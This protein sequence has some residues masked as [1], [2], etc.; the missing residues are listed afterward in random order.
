MQ[1]TLPILHSS[2]PT[3]SPLGSKWSDEDWNNNRHKK[4]EERKKE[5]Q[6]KEEAKKKNKE[7]SSQKNYHPQVLCMTLTLKKTPY[8][9]Q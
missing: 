4:R 5:Q 7:E 2:S 8:Q 3:S 9:P 6:E 1:S